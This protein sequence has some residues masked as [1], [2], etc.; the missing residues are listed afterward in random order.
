MVAIAWLG[1]FFG[2]FSWLLGHHLL[3]ARVFLIVAR[4]LLDCCYRVFFVV[5]KASLDCC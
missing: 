1:C 3:V 2:S 4:A 5:A